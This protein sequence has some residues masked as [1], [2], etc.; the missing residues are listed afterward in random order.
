LVSRGERF[1]FAAPD[2]EGFL[3]GSTGDEADDYAA[4]LQGVAYL[5]RLCFD[6]LDLLGAP[7][8]GDLT[9]TGGAARSEYWCRLRAQVLGRPV[10]LPA[11]PEPALGAA[12]LAASPGR[13]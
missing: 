8:D 5:E 11:D 9:F 2:A 7:V 6:H 3:L 1:P 13:R 12:V 10:I 4:L